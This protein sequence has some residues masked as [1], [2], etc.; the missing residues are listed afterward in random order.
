MHW[1][2]PCVSSR[3]TPRRRR[4]PARPPGWPRSW[5]RWTARRTAI[6]AEPGGRVRWWTF[7]GAYAN[8]AL[9]AG[10]RALGVSTGRSALTLSIGR[11]AAERAKIGAN[12]RQASRGADVLMRLIPFAISVSLFLALSSSSASLLAIAPNQYEACCMSIVGDGPVD[13][14]LCP[15]ELPSREVCLQV[16]E[17]FS[18]A[19]RRHQ[20]LLSR[21]ASASNT[22][23]PAPSP[24]RT[25]EGWRLRVLLAA[26][27]ASLAFV[28]HRSRRSRV[29]IVE[30]P[31][32]VSSMPTTKRYALLVSSAVI[33]LGTLPSLL[34]LLS[35]NHAGATFIVMALF[36]YPTAMLS[37]V[38]L[39]YL[40]RVRRVHGP[41]GTETIA[42]YTA[43]LSVALL[44]AAH[45]FPNGTLLR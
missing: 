9:A 21:P 16:V 45:V 38:L 29:P 8:G 26:I 31:M 28:L 32:S 39:L 30:G 14:A 19:A 6:V 11:H 37:A 15:E 27:V 2:H 33:V 1:P 34:Y 17:D 10:L 4:M 20:R 7:A 23:R 41:S 24:R 43:I 40:M 42:R 5:T 13:R 3:W 25:I 12:R 35:H 18:E 44:I 36:G 22:Q